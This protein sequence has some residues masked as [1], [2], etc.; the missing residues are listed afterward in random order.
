MFEF[1]RSSNNDDQKTSVRKDFKTNDQW[2]ELI[3]LSHKQNVYIFKHS[4]RCGISSMILKRFERQVQ[5]RNENYFYLH[6]Q[7]FRS[8]SNWLSQELDIRHESPQ[9]IV[10]KDAKVLDHASHSAIVDVLPKL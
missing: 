10:L 4:S 8:I 6:I 7:A 5:E 1:L 9:L 3:E 2:S